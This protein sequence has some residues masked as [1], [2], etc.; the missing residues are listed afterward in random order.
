MDNKQ[1]YI[2]QA[3]G[4]DLVNNDFEIKSFK[5][6]KVAFDYSLDLIKIKEIN[7]KYF[8]DKNH[9]FYNDKDKKDKKI[10]SSILVSVTFK[11]K[12]EDMKTEQIR[13]K[14]YRDGFYIGDKHYIRFKR[15][16]GAS[17]VGK[18]LFILEEYYDYIMEYSYMN[19]DFSDTNKEIDLA[20]LEAYISLTTSSIIDTI[21]IKTNEILVIDDYDSIFTDTIISTKNINGKLHT[22]ETTTEISNCIFDGQSLLDKS[23]F[24]KSKYSNK[25]MLLLRNRFFKSCCFNTN[26][27]QFFADNNIT[28]ISQLNGFTKAR[29]IEQIK[30]IT[31][32]SSIKYLKFGNLK[33]FLKYTDKT[34]GIVKYEKGTH[35]FENNLVKTH[36][37]LIN[38]LEFS[39]EK[40][41]EFLEPTYKYIKILKEE[42][43]FMRYHLKMTLDSLAEQD[44]YFNLSTSLNFIQTMLGIN[45]EITKTNMY[46][47]FCKETVKNIVK[48]CRAGHILVN[49]NYSTLFGNG[50]EMLLHSIGK[51][52]GNSILNKDEVI[53]YRFN[54]NETILGSRSP[55]ITMGNIWLMKNVRNENIE[56]YFNLTKEIILVNAI[57]NNLLERL[58]GCD[59]DSDTVLLTN[60]NILIDLAQKNYNNFLVPTSQVKASKTKR[61]NNVEHKTDLD[62]KTSV[63]KIGE[64]VNLSQILNSVLWEY[65]KEN[66]DY[67]DIYLDICKLSVMSNIAID[68][69]KKEFD[70]NLEVELN[71]LRT[72]YEQYVKNK[73]LFFYTLPVPDRFKKSKEKYMKYETSMDYLIL[74][75]DNTGLKTRRKSTKTI[76][77][78][79]LFNKKEIKNEKSRDY[80]I[81]KVFNL[82]LQYK[83]QCNNIW[84]SNLDGSEKY[85]RALDL[86]MELFNNI[87]KIKLNSITLLNIIKMADKNI[88]RTLIGL[89]FETK[90]AEFTKLINLH[91]EEIS[92]LEIDKSSKNEYIK[93]FDIKFV[94]K[95]RNI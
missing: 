52:D 89:L 27:Q 1:V 22:K 9:F 82:V 65:K 69:A 49:G 85:Y 51:F 71:E 43:K 13:E 30:M 10:Y 75:L 80:H 68:M 44:K 74:S 91:K 88:Q 16:S 79:D 11:Y 40:M 67:K 66:K 61:Y 64:I 72:K 4:K 28:K 42:P 7:K 77:I 53:S 50:Y 6:Y 29:K 12:T 94:K 47:D 45:D 83:N 87:K 57:K 21:D 84:Q 55:H 35:Y 31:T 92:F 59:Y 56:K 32:P 15:S 34:F 46:K 8:N 93:I 48:D 2:V 95:T 73:P 41:E 19:L 36:Y 86:K 3:D 60:N 63:N 24:D 62:K 26:I 17:R 5:R 81:N 20:S 70:I 78:I 14:L 90:R 58:A 37:Q 25:G 76:N 38:T 39:Q 33:D 18:C 54:E 23:I